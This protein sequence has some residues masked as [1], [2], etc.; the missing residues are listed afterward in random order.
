MPWRGCLPEPSAALWEKP[1]NITKSAE[2]LLCYND[3]KAV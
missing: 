3:D 1:Y 2:G